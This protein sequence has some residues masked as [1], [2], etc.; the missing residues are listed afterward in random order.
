M[1]TVAET[2]FESEFPGFQS[3]TVIIIVYT[4]FRTWM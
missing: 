4:L 1:S 2:G 3:S